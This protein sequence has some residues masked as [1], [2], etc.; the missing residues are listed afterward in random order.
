LPAWGFAAAG[1]GVCLRGHGRTA[2]CGLIML[3]QTRGHPGAWGPDAG[4]T[5]VAAVRPGHPG[6][7]DENLI[8]RD[9][10]GGYSWYRLY[11]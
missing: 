1:L 7:V 11:R 6:G 9:D 10:E 4:R 8:R 2:L 5:P 3:A